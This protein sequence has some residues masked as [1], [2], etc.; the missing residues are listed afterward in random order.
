MGA[1]CS[2]SG[3]QAA[4]SR[5]GPAVDR[6]LGAGDVARV[7]GGEEGHHGGDLVRAA[8]A[9][10]REGLGPGG[11]VSSHG[12]VEGLGEEFRRVLQPVLLPGQ[13]T[14]RVVG[15]EEVLAKAEP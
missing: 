6:P 7:V 12:Q 4:V 1:V 8:E 2:R 9:P 14:Q 5:G 3:E 13:E 15:V 11:V 10:Q